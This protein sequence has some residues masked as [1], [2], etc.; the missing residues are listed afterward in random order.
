MF[1][2]PQQTD[3][4]DLLNFCDLKL[5]LTPATEDSRLPVHNFAD[6][7]SGD[8]LLSKSGES[9]PFGKLFQDVAVDTKKKFMPNVQVDEVVH[10]SPTSHQEC[11]EMQ[12]VFLTMSKPSVF[13]NRKVLS[14]SHQKV[15]LSSVNESVESGGSTPGMLRPSMLCMKPPPK[16]SK[17]LQ[18][19]PT[20]N[21][22]EFQYLKNRETVQWTSAVSRLTKACEAAVILDSVNCIVPKLWGEI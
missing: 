20:L 2:A 5:S 11:M 16:L 8:G 10:K 19:T 7:F 1:S 12:D 21:S 15:Y 18:V 4:L 3:L 14:L 22:E 9:S 17:N 6:L 13:Q